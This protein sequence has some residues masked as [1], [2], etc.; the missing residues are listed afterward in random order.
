MLSKEVLVKCN[1]FPGVF[2]TDYEVNLGLENK[3]IVHE[4]FLIK[5]DNESGL[6]R[7][8]CADK[9][10]RNSTVIIYDLIKGEEVYLTIPNNQ[11]SPYLPKS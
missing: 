11:I 6:V 8:K 7:A 3:F 1:Y 5:K 2:D 9:G 4:D 10:W